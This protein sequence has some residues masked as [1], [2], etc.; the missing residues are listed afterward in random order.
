MYKNFKLCCKFM[1]RQILF[2]NFLQILR[3]LVEES[4][5]KVCQCWLQ[6]HLLHAV[7]FKPPTPVCMCSDILHPYHKNINVSLN[8]CP[9]FTVD[10]ASRVSPTPLY[11]SLF[12]RVRGG[13]WGQGTKAQFDLSLKVKLVPE[14]S[15]WIL[16]CMF[17]IWRS[18]AV[19][20]VEN[21]LCMCRLF[22][23]LDVTAAL[24]PTPPSLTCR[25]S[26]LIR[27]N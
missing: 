23:F 11:E 19:L 21:W 10:A 17:D 7:K 14:G 25:S 16:I 2:S 24:T 5:P 22:F 18:E 12:S 13:W 20:S 27:T 6:C 4:G 8:W 26:L 1:F 9:K 3:L 15:S